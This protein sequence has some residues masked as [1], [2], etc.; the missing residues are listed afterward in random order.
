MQAVQRPE[1]E[2]DNQSGLPLIQLNADLPAPVS[3]WHLYEMG[4]LIH[5]RTEAGPR[6]NVGA[7]TDWDHTSAEKKRKRHPWLD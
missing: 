3:G 6:L 5:A 1:E 7:G 4:Q 2:T